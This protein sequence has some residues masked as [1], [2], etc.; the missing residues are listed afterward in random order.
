MRK[1]LLTAAAAAAFVAT[2]A[3]ADGPYVGIEG[4]VLFPQKQDIFGTVNFTNPAPVA[5]DITRSSV[6]NVDYDVGYDVDLIGGFDLGMFRL[7]GELGYKRASLK[8]Y[9]FNNTFLTAI[10]AGNGTIYNNSNINTQFDLAR[11]TDIYSAMINGLVDF[12]GNGGIGA[13]AGG[14]AGYADV[15]QFGDRQGKF[16]WQLIAGAYAPISSNINIG[17]KY[18]YFQTENLNFNDDFSIAAPL[19]ANCGAN[20]CSPAIV[21]FDT[22][23]HFS[24]HSLLASLVFNFG[25]PAMVEMAP[26]PPPPPPMVEA[27]QT[28]P[29][30]SVIAASSMCPMPPPPPPPPPAPVERGE[31]GQ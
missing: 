30:G 5:A 8:D 14:G 15:H 16:A 20:V 23:R 29:D 19:G 9:T 7:E 28:C 22:D 17:L 12:G 13:Y 27:T 11:H 6:A 21:T 31:R 1:Y 10:T 2:P 24:S 18:R 25:A 26:P 3:F 4:G